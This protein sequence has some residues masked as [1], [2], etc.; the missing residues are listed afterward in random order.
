[1]RAANNKA[2]GETQIHQTLR[3]CGS[4]I[5]DSTLAYFTRNPALAELRFHF[6]S[7]PR[8]FLLGAARSADDAQEE[9]FQCKLLAGN[10]V[11]V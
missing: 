5:R 4:A 2:S 7:Q 11:I 6:S 8:K 10:S 9:L 3:K 1:M